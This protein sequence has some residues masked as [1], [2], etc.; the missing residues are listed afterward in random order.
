LSIIFFY[1]LLAWNGWTLRSTGVLAAVFLAFLLLDILHN[2]YFSC[3]NDFDA[4]EY[5]I[6][7][8]VAVAP[9]FKWVDD[10]AKARTSTPGE[11]TPLNLRV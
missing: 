7:A 10:K 5:V 9:G 3:I 4:V 11:T 1:A 2:K 6:L 8:M